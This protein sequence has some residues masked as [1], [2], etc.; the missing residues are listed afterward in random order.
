MLGLGRPVLLTLSLLIERLRLVF[1]RTSGGRGFSGKVLVLL[2][3]DPGLDAE[4]VFIVAGPVEPNV[5]RPAD[6][7][8]GLPLEVCTELPSFEVTGTA[9]AVFAPNA[10][11]PVRPLAAEDDDPELEEFPEFTGGTYMKRQQMCQRKLPEIMR[12]LIHYCTK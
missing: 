9:L 4:P 12:V 5:F 3:P 6:K 10:A 8:G 7:V 1:P 11:Q 2:L